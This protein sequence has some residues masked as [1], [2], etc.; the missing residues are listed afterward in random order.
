VELSELS[1]SELSAEIER[2]AAQ[3]Q[4][5]LELAEGQLL[6]AVLFRGGAGEGARLLI[7]IHHLVVDGVSWRVLL[8]D[9]QSAYEQLQS[10]RAETAVELLP[11]TTSFLGWARELEQFGRSAAV[12]AESEYWLAVAG[13]SEGAGQ[14]P[15]DYEGGSNLE[16]DA[17]RVRMELTAAETEA[18]LREVPGRY[19]TEVNDALLTGLGRVLWRWTGARRQLVELEGHGREEFAAELDVTRT[20]GWF[21]T[22]FPV[23]LEVGAGLGTD[24]KAVK[25][26]LRR[27]PR[28]GL[29]YGLLRYASAVEHEGLRG[30]SAPIVFNYLGQLD[31][32]VSGP[33]LF[34]PARESAG[35]NMWGGSERGHLLAVNASVVGGRLRVTWNYSRKLHRQETIARLA[36]SLLEE[37]RALIAHCREQ[38]AGGFTPSDFPAAQLNQIELDDFIA[39]VSLN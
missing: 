10:G 39:S 36:Q 35:A 37:L 32:A 25:E 23:E 29:S 26:R 6:R 38:D 7:V 31:G 5:S 12:Q 15:L 20:V 17:A 3:T 2:L 9:W 1:G 13:G 16:R 28:R 34:R 21:T 30:R 18:L 19:R 11:E 8:E 33:S 24:L 22:V 14:L 4:R 27:V